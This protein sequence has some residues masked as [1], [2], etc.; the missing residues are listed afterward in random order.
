MKM[1]FL[2][3]D[4]FCDIGH[5]RINDIPGQECD[6]ISTLLLAAAVLAL[7][8]TVLEIAFEDPPGGVDG[9]LVPL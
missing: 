5:F 2:I 8:W 1:D 3:R 7:R 4:H 9:V 6:R